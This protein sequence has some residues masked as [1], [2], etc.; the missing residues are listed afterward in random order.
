MS[1]KISFL[2]LLFFLVFNSFSCV[3]LGVAS[4]GAYYFEGRKVSDL[5]KYFQSSEIEICEPE[6]G[7]DS[8][9]FCSNEYIVYEF[10]K[11]N[12]IKYKQE[13]MSNIVSFSFTEFGDGCKCIGYKDH[14]HHRYDA[15][16]NDVIDHNND[17]PSINNNINYFYKLVNNSRCYDIDERNIAFSKSKVG[18]TY[19]L[20][21]IKTKQTVFPDIITTGG[22]FRNYRNAVVS[23]YNLYSVDIVEKEERETE[24]HYLSYKFVYDIY[25]NERKEIITQ[26]EFDNLW[27]YYKANGYDL[28]HS[29]KGITICAHVKDGKII[30]VETEEDLDGNN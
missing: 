25:Y 18:D 23:S 3:S 6:E 28:E 20:A 21:S 8:T 1:K 9:F 30:K 10:S 5:Y 27:N 2:I 29:T 16:G 7:Y 24:K 4:K 26:K 19:L 13:Q 12:I 15:F 22:R 17:N 11:T 14:Y